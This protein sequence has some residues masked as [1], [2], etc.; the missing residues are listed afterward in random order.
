MATSVAD[1][2]QEVL[3]E[4]FAKAKTVAFD[5]AKSQAYLYPIKVRFW[6]H[7]PPPKNEF[8][9]LIW[10]TT[11]R[12]ASSTLRHIDLCGNRSCRVWSHT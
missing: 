7:T 1:K 8:L 12:R 9:T 5:A 6:L 10:L 4:D 11:S 2:A 3:K